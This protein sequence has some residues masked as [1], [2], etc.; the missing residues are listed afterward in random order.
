VGQ[1]GVRIND[2]GFAWNVTNP[3]SVIRIASF[4]YHL[5]TLGSDDGYQPAIAP[6]GTSVIDGAPFG[7]FGVTIWTMPKLAT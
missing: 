3:A 1:V 2:F 6:D 5:P 7:Y 4:V